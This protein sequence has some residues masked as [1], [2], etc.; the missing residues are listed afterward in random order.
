MVQASGSAALLALAHACPGISRAEAARRL[1][2]PSGFA[3]ETT[4]RLVASQLLREA[5]APPTGRRGRPTTSLVAHPAGPLV[6]VA[7]IAHETFRVAAVQLGGT[8]IASLQRPHR[9][10][11]VQ[12]QG[13]V[14]GELG[15]IH[16]RFSGRIR[17]FVVSV[18]GTVTG[19]RLVHAPNLGWHDIDLSGLQPS[20]APDVP[21]IAGNDATFAGIA[22][23]WRGAAAG[24]RTAVHLYL[25]AGVGGAYLDAGRPVLG[26][27][28]TAG[29]FGHMAFGSPSRTCQ[30]GA[31]GC[32]NTTLDGDAI[33]RSLHQQP[34]ADQVS[35]TRQVLA[36]AQA[37]RPAERRA[38]RAVARSLG[39]G[40][41]ALVNALD[42]SIV[43]IGGLGR[44]VLALADPEAQRAYGDGLMAFRSATPPPPLVP[45]R[46]GA[47][48]PVLGAAD[49]GFSRFLS[50]D[51]TSWTS[52]A[53]T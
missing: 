8:A 53:T 10:D 32:W 37:G 16:R 26:A 25:D 19:T 35:Y 13:A 48:G 2:M 21:L 22:E 51:I 12:V 40:A 42:P 47:N 49:E 27:T 28:G 4:A 31:R 11:L 50:E 20:Q 14:R 39:R 45:G 6:A 33:A 17:A 1:G 15:E 38:I 3:T 9:R 43:T 23:Y 29:E 46:F 52:K 24:A 44:I 34:P 30:C 18:P 7:D 36:S 5:P 41:A